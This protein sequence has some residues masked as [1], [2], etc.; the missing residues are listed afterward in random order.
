MT[1]VC[2]TMV[3]RA[4]P[5][6]AWALADFHDRRLLLEHAHAARLVVCK[7]LRM[8]EGAC[9]QPDSPRS[10]RE[11]LLNGACQEMPAQTDADKCWQQSEVRHLDARLRLRL[12]L[13]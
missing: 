8:I 6:A 3:S 2:Q 13:E 11:A 5:R 9:V 10:R 7:R 1:Q 4:G 12:Q